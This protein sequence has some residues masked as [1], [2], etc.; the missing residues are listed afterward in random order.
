M[1]SKTFSQSK[2]NTGIRGAQVGAAIGARYCPYPYSILIGGIV[3]YVI[4][5][6]ADEVID[7]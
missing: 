3:G 6:V 5:I 4:A 2:K 1:Q 7:D